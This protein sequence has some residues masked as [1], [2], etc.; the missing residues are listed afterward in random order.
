[1]TGHTHVWLI[2]I[3]GEDCPPWLEAAW[4]DT[5]TADNIQGWRE[6]VEQCREIARQAKGEI[7]VQEV[8]VPAVNEMF[9]VPQVTADLVAGQ[10]DVPEAVSD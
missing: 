4:D 3:Q 8:R 7:R 5:S 1:M 10:G 9:E 6:T 2:W